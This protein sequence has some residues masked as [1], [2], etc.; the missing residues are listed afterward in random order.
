MSFRRLSFEIRNR[1]EL[2]MAVEERGRQK[3]LSGGEGSTVAPARRH[4]YPLHRSRNDGLP[5]PSALVYHAEP[6]VARSFHLGLEVAGFRVKSLSHIETALSELAASPYD[7]V[8]VSLPYPAPAGL[9]LL[10]RFEPSRQGHLGVIG[11]ATGLNELERK[12][13]EAMGVTHWV[14]GDL[15]TRETIEKVAGVVS[16]HGYL[17]SSAMRL[18][19]PR[20]WSR[21]LLGPLLVDSLER[22]AQLGQQ[23]RSLSAIQSRL[24]VYFAENN[25]AH[26]EKEILS[27][28]WG[29]S[30]PKP[31]TKRVHT[32]IHTVRDMF[33]AQGNL[34]EWVP[35]VGFRLSG[36]FAEIRPAI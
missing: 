4:E 35:G 1:L 8:V 10:R 11:I 17:R 15:S 24:L 18:W 36:P 6:A 9:D 12:I 26:P 23:K 20:S 5:W 13:A 14:S 27:D 34:I 29:L 30:D 22:F 3:A 32:T 16:E 19:C 7:L 28:V 31:K 2:L 33:R 25:A 21:F